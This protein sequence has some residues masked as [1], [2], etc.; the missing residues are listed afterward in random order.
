MLKKT[1]ISVFVSNSIGA[2]LGFLI[3]LIL[4]RFLSVENFGKV[5]LIFTLVVILFTITDFGFCNTVV[6]FYN[7]KKKDAVVNP[8]FFLN[9]IY[10]KFLFVIYAIS[11]PIVLFFKFYF[12]LSVNESIIIY[13]IFALFLIYRYLN[14]INQAKGNWLRYNLLNIFNNLC[15]LICFF[16]FTIFLYFVFHLLSKYDSV[17]FGYGT[18]AVIIII[19]SLIVNRENIKFSFRNVENKAYFKEFLS[20]IIPL[21]LANIFII[22][23]MRFGNLI[24]EKKLGSSYLGIYSAANTLALVFPLITTSIMNVLLREASGK[25]EDFLEKG[26]RNQ[27]KYLLL[28]II[29]LIVSILL[30]KYFVVILFGNK[31]VDSI[32]IFRILLI[33]YIGPLIMMVPTS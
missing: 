21:G 13:I 14:S 18:Y 6:I 4:A 28:L 32:N 5:N 8:I 31:Y 3:N 1:L 27:K 24:I 25:K 9:S 20:I 16:T 17:L 12:N 23:T 19:V 2:G 26:I 22:I 15:K 10:I 29:I 11:I 33:P 30:S 7:R